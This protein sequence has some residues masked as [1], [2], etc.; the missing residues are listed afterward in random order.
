MPEILL[1]RTYDRHTIKNILTNP[2][3]YSRMADDYAPDREVFEPANPDEAAYVQVE[4][5]GCVKGLWIL[6]PHSQTLW[7]VHTA[8]LSEIWGSVAKQAAPLLLKWV[9]DNT[10]C[11]RLYTLVPVASRAVRKFAMYA[12]MEECGVHEKCFLKDG[13]LQDLIIMGINRSSE[14]AG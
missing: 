11:Q 2:K 5:D 7:E 9:W 8:L 4:V 3:I 13:E 12:G 6:V 10:I 14:K 1:S